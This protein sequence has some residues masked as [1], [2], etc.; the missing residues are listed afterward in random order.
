MDKVK[1]NDEEIFLD[2]DKLKFDESNLSEYLENEAS[3]YNYYGQKLADAEHYYQ[4]C[5]L[6]VEKVSADKFV[7]FKIGKGSDK[8]C[9]ACVDSDDDVQ[10]LKVKAMEA[11]RYVR[12]LH[13]HLRA[14]DRNH[15][16]AIQLGHNLRRE[17]DK[18]QPKIYSKMDD[19]IDS[20]V[21]KL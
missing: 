14:W 15:D 17:M 18:L 2:P 3:W 10:E 7:R 9:E 20:V 13:Q 21:R 11:K 4:K 5:E 1:V 8:Y 16:N 19:Q 6:A 12:K